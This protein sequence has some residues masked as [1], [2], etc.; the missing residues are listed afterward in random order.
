MT[1][2]IQVFTKEEFGEIRT[3]E[4]DGKILFCGNDISN[5]LGYKNLSKR[6]FD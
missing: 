5:V 2:E 1:N 4:K 3:V 6:C